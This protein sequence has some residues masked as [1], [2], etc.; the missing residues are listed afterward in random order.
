[1][2]A[3][4]DSDQVS[5]VNTATNKLVGGPVEA[6]E[7]PTSVAITPDGKYAY[8]TDVEGES[9][10]V[11]ETGLR[12]N[13]ATIEEVGEE[14]FGIAITPDGK[15]AYVTDSGSNEVAVISTPDQKSREVDP[16]RHRTDRASRSRRPAN[17]PTSPNYADN[18]VEVINTETMTR[19]R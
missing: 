5:F 14:P 10:S 9:V 1:M 11:I 18:D 2:V 8:V 7:G 16:G 12:R 3:E 13:V 6:G 4:R 15:Y 17:S 19:S